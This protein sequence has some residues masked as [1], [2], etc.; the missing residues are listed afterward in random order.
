MF[1]FVVCM[2]QI[3]RGEQSYRHI[4]IITPAFVFAFLLGLWV[5]VC[6]GWGMSVI[7]SGVAF[8]LKFFVAAIRFFICIWF[9]VEIEGRW[10]WKLFAGFALLE[11]AVIWG[12]LK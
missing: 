2:L 3:L 11:T 4:E 10:Y 1:N 7:I 6:Y 12:I 8:I 5:G 9:D